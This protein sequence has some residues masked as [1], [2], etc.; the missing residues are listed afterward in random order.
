MLQKT[1]KV[2]WPSTY[3]YFIDIKLTR[4]SITYFPKILNNLILET[5]IDLPS[6]TRFL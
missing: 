1:N 4:V 2:V 5:T 6:I 3:D